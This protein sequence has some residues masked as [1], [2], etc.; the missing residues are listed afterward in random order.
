MWDKCTKVL[1][2]KVEIDLDF[3]LI[4]ILFGLV[5]IGKEFWP[6]HTCRN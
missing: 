2:S 3:F 4:M 6:T 1:N 5:T